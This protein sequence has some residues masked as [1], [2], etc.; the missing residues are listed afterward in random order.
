MSL[1]IRDVR[2]TLTSPTGRN[3]VIVKVLTSEPDLH[4]IGCAT[5]TQRYLPVRS[6]V[7]DYLKPLLIGR[8]PARI[9]ELHRLMSVNSYWRGGPVLN[10]AISGVDMALWDIKA[11]LAGMPLYDLLGGKVREAA[12]VYQHAD[13][14][15]LKELQDHVQQQVD[16]GMSHVRIRFGGSS[17][18]TRAS[19]E[20]GGN[21]YGGAGLGTQRPPDGALDGVYYDP[22]T[23]TRTTIEAIAHIRKHFGDDIELLHDVHERLTPAQAIRF[24]KDLE[25]FRLFFLEDPIAPEDLGWYERLRNATTTPIAA[26]EL[27]TGPNEWLPL[28]SNRLIDFVRMHISDIGGLTPAKKVATVAETFG[29]RTAWHGPGDCSPV[30]HAVNLHLNLSTLN[31]GI[32]ELQPF[33][34]LDREI[35]IGCPEYR[36]GYLYPN[37]KPGHGIDL[38]EA[39]AAKYPCDPKTIMWT[40]A[41]LPDGSLARP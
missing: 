26:S 12:A 14:R 24:A 9:E 28:V 11:K 21:A 17:E 29:V 40:Q 25:P 10:N 30:G 3:L 38:N 15:D 13:G 2:V 18:L 33:T 34:D 6:A 19:G 37:D 20:A 41:R 31:F 4:G 22:Q 39:L 27:F 32:H 5:F 16:L 7:E 23:Y 1:T 35:F 36:N 8:D